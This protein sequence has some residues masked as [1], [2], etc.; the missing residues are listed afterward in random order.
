[1]S[2][3]EQPETVDW[4]RPAVAFLLFGG[5]A[6][7]AAD[8]EALLHEVFDESYAVTPA[9]GDEPVSITIEDATVVVQP[10]DGPAGDGEPARFTGELAIWNG[11][12][13]VVD[14]HRS[15]LV[16]GAERI[17]TEGEPPEEMD[18]RLEALRCELA[19][20]HV[21]AALTA[22][23]GALAVFLPTAAATLPA[24]PYRDIV[25]SNPIPV[26]ALVGV[27][28]GWFEE[29]RP[30]VYTSGLGRFG[31]PDMER[32]ATEGHPGEVYGQMCDLL[33]FSLGTGTVFQPG[34]TLEVAEGEYLGVTAGVSEATGWEV[35][36]LA[37]VDAPPAEAPS[38]EAPS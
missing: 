32:F 1:M 7:A 25:V 28:A 27:R 5:D 12:E 17:G 22:L 29:G 10:V 23:P 26:P 38:T 9:H 13:D 20:A 31:R 8:V 33:A 18:P 21:T 35:L 24:E 19:V 37:P 2:S 16:V 6:P 11:G 36:Q 15:H 30:Y 4:R 14:G 34:Q 3:P